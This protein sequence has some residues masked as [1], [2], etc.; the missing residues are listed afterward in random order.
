MQTISGDLSL[1]DTACERVLA[2]SVSGDV[3]FGGPLAK[4][5]RYEFSTHS[6][7]VRLSLQGSVGFEITA[8]SFSGE[9]RSDLRCRAAAA[10]RRRCRPAR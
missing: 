6:G 3:Q 9:L 7:D 4:A 5:G 10:A 1:T 8:N 2:K